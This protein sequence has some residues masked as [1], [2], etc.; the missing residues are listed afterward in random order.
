[1][2]I[3]DDGSD[4]N[5]H[6]GERKG[7]KNVAVAQQAPGSTNSEGHRC[8]LYKPASLRS[9]RLTVVGVLRHADNPT[10]VYELA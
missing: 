4:D 10:P 6:N 8:P 5:A 2:R 9:P 3:E 7:D 1:M